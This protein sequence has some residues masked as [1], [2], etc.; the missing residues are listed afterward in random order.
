M[1]GVM[2]SLGRTTYGATPD[3]EIPR[4]PGVR[5]DDE[6]A[7]QRAE[8]L[9]RI[10]DP[11]S[12]Q[13]T[14]VGENHPERSM[15]SA[16]AEAVAQRPVSGGS[17]GSGSATSD[18]APLPRISAPTSNIDPQDPGGDAATLPRIPQ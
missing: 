1:E 5:D 7:R 4:I 3:D 8:Q 11:N 15:L 14:H 9:T 6:E 10:G 12:W 16:P 2:T 17:T 13:V 18:D